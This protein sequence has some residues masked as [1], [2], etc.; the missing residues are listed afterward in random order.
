MQICSELRKEV[1]YIR[2]EWGKCEQF[3]DKISAL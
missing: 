3:I 2:E 1:W